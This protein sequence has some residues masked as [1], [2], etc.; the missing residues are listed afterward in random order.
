MLIFLKWSPQ[1][2]RRCKTMRGFITLW[3]A[4][5]WRDLRREKH[6]LFPDLVRVPIPL[7]ANRIFMP[8]LI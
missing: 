4:C 7:P 8:V 3:S 1:P 6:I 5:P 2:S